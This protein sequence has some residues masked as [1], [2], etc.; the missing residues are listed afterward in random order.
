MSNASAGERFIDR[1]D[2]D[3]ANLREIFGDIA[4]DSR[5]ASDIIANV[6]NTIKKG[7]AMREQIDLN[8]I[9]NQVR[10]MVR[11]DL[12]AHSCELHLSLAENLP[13]AEG[14]PIQIQQ[15]LINLVTNA[16]DAMRNTPASQ[17]KVEIATERNGN[18]TI[19]VSVR[20]VGA[21][22]SDEVREHLFDQFFTTKEE[23]LGMGLAIVRSIIESH[24]GKI[25][26][27][28]NNGCGACFY[29]VLPTRMEAEG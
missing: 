20:D 24:G 4:A 10:H 22:I 29:F 6:R 13:A 9:A 16:C 17:R 27:E 28:K 21:G 7:A 12:I 8:E 1:G 19:R 18:G 3:L 5:R 26:A 14:D 2:V 11:P 25:D 15:V 23:G